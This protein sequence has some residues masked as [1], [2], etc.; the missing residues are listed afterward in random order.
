M[1]TESVVSYL[2]L[3]LLPLPRVWNEE[4]FFGVRFLFIFGYSDEY[5]CYT[6]ISVALSFLWETLCLLFV[7]CE[8]I[9]EFQTSSFYKDLG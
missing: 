3:S 4:V 7:S 8:L 9:S 1:S 2:L 5:S 6:D